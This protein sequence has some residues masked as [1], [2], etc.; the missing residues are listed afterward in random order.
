MTTSST[1]STTPASTSA[2]TPAT[3]RTRV[4][5]PQLEGRRWLNTGGRELGLADLRGKVVLLDFWTSCCVNC[6][7]VLDEL[8]EVEERFSDVLVVVGV[9][10]PKFRFEAEPATLDAA[11]E[12]YAVHHPVLDDPELRTW[13]AYTARAWPTLVVVDPEGYVVASM[14]GEGHAHGLGVLLE[15]LVA[16][17]GAR[18]TLHRGSG[19]YVAPE[20]PASALRFPARV[21]A[22]PDGGFLVAD[23]A[24]HQ[25]VQLAEDLQTEVRRVGDGERGHV[26][27]SASAARFAEPQGFCL[28][29]GDVAARV[30]YDL[31][32]ADSVNHALRGVRLA[33]GAV[34]T[35]AGTGRQLRRREGGGPA[36]EQD[37]STPWDVAWFDG[38]VVVAMAGVHQLWAFD[39]AA[40]PADGVV[41]VLAGTTAEGVQDGPAERAWFAQTS[42]FAVADGPDGPVLWFVDAETSA[43]RTLRRSGSEGPDRGVPR[44]DDDRLANVGAVA[45]AGYE[46]RTAVGQG[47]FDFGFRDGPG[48]PADGTPPALLQHPLGLAIAPDGSVLVA[49]TYNGALRRYDPATGEVSTLLRDLAEPSDVL[50]DAGGDADGDGSLVVVEAAGHRLTRFAVPP[51][52]RVDAGAHTV[53]RPPTDLAAGPVELSVAFTPPTGQKLDDRWGDPTR[54]VVAASPPELLLE[55]AGEAEGLRRRLVLDAAVGSGVLHVSVQAA[56]CDGDPD[57]GEVPEF[58]ACHLYQQDWGIPVRLVD[59]APAALPLDLR[60]A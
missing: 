58:A 29:P 14:S 31:V 23:T 56:A 17:H 57:T 45:G 26:D 38:Q 21:L 42:G 39:P 19:P 55:G 54:L 4:R 5:A 15:E 53:Q 20:P 60:G 40:D 28:L 22:L 32:V 49:D 33:D 7:H 1:R 24:H 41:R 11:V 46:V 9:H 18:G 2:S 13:G 16:E 3:R 59:G 12:R 48:A 25:L 35:V 10:S 37:L 47:L 27:G 30:G 43:L 6:L 50:V 44:V 8:R 34:T 51:E 52:A 36:L